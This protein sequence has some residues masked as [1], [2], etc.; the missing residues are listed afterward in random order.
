MMPLVL[1]VVVSLAILAFAEL[2]YRRLES[3]NRTMSGALALQSAVN[4]V[5]A[6]V[7]NAETGQ[8]GFLLTGDPK[9]LQPYRDALPRFEQAWG[10]VRDLANDNATASM[11]EHLGKLNNLIGKKFN[12]IESTLELNE[13]SGREAAFQLIDTGI[14][15]RL[16]DDIRAE[17][18]AIT[19]EINLSS[20]AGNTRWSRDIEFGRIGMLA[21]T[22]FTIALLL[23]VWS[24]AKREIGLREDRRRRLAEE[25][26]HL[27][28]EITARTAEL[29]ELSNYLQTVREEEKSRLARDIH[30]ELGGIL[31]GAK[32]DVAWAADRFKTKDPE[33]AGKLSR[34]LTMLDEGVEMKR[35]IIE[36]LRPTLLDNLGLAAALDWQVRQTCERAGLDCKLNLADGD[37]ELPP[38]VA[39]ALY[40]IVQEAM[41]NIVKYAQARSVS[42]ELVRDDEGVTVIVQDDGIGLPP[43]ADTNVLSH[44]IQGMRQRVRALKGEFHIHGKPRAGTTLEI[45]IPLNEPLQE[46]GDAA[47]EERAAETE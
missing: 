32:M 30:D 10:R 28:R 22:A 34:A 38:Q 3:A 16:M 44:G 46:E 2:G 7:V 43:G 6:Q 45:S 23:V 35:R 39:I 21:M 29:S 11:R 1:G 27:E 33:T 5:L 20:D 12:E 42:V 47:L 17:V 9:Y 4:E 37:R 19:D 24:L 31:V 8:R 18:K 26:E 14:G 25:R 15:Q 13:K 36:E 41:T 40:R